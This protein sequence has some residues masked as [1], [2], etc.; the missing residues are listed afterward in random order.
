MRHLYSKMFDVHRPKMSDL[1]FIDSVRGDKKLLV[2]NNC[3]YYEFRTSIHFVTR[4]GDAVHVDA[5][6]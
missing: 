1:K 5:Q 4:R 2:F 6:P 3:T